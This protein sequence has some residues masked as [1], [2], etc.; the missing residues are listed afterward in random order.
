MNNFK[1]YLEKVAKLQG[2]KK[3]E[4]IGRKGRIHIIPS[5]E[6]NKTVNLP[7]NSFTFIAQSNVET[8]I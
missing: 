3:L 2:F 5:K 1:I 7:I 4:G 8:H 6:V